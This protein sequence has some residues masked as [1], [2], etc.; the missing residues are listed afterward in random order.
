MRREQVLKICANHNLRADMDLTRMNDRA[1][2]WVALDFADEEVRLEKLC[3]RFKMSDEAANFKDAFDRAK[4]IVSAAET[5]PATA[6]ASV[7]SVSTP[8]LTQDPSKVAAKVVTPPVSSSVPVTSSCNKI[9]V[10]G[11][12]FASPP[13]FKT[14][15]KSAATQALSKDTTKDKEKGSG[16]AVKP[17][18]FA[19]FSFTSP[20]KVSTSMDSGIVTASEPTPLRRS[21]TSLPKP[22]NVS[23]TT[24]DTVQSTPKSSVGNTQ[25]SEVKSVDSS[26]TKLMF[27]S[28]HSD[29]TFS[30]LASVNKGSGFKKDDNFKG[31][32]GAGKSV[33]GGSL[34]S[35][36]VDENENENEGT[37]EEFVPTAEF[38]PVVPLPELVEL[39]T[40][41]EGE[42]ILFEERAKLLRFDSE[43]KQWKERG[44]GKVKI[45]QDPSTGKVR[46]LMRREQVLKVCCNHFVTANMKFTA[47][48]TSDRAWTWYAQDYSEGEMKL[49][50]LAIKFKTVGQALSFKKTLEDVQGKMSEKDRDTNKPAV[51]QA[52]SSQAVV[53][54]CKECLFPNASDA[55][56]CLSCKMA[57]PRQMETPAFASHGSSQQPKLLELSKSTESWD[58]QSCCLRNDNDSETCIGC[59]KPKCTKAASLSSA[60]GAKPLTELFKAKPG[61]WECKSCYKKNQGTADLCM[62][63][64]APKPGSNIT[65]KPASSFSF[66][67]LPASDE[68]IV[69]IS[70][71]FKPKAGSWECKECYTRNDA[72]KT[73]CLCCSGSKPGHEVTQKEKSGTATN[74][75]SF[76]FGVPSSGTSSQITSGQ[77]DFTFGSIA[78]SSTS[79]P[80]KYNFGISVS[81]A[82]TSTVTATTTTTTTTAAIQSLFTNSNGNTPKSGFS[83]GLPSTTS[84][85]GA[86]STS[87]KP[88]SFEPKAATGAFLFG[89]SAGGGTEG[90]TSSLT[91][92]FGSS[93][94]TEG[95]E[96]STP[97]KDTS[98]KI[99]VD[100]NNL[101]L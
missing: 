4:G 90:N 23:S 11:F 92:S 27:D 88:F 89:S 17:S 7:P 93:M 24:S 98:G 41:E 96:D 49:E 29:L 53:W 70:E 44:I 71:L 38:K 64:E 99:S 100:L 58:C 62:A 37:A 45:M 25:T 94:Q 36:G 66:G 40:G 72:N 82:S 3:V 32:E 12:T 83:F 5:S 91:F 95:K 28:P 20:P 14:D 60:S 63:C 18:P 21:R 79:E 84:I 19:G 34:K 97:S 47:L 9:T 101:D 65:A 22:V 42:N 26:G 6:T 56:H 39:K 78:P 43:G 8:S 31:W 50:L 87:T 68:N 61:L 15:S 35:E 86:D 77:S 73:A 75:P 52:N 85:F 59:K 69:P 76:M 81:S 16:D 2:M 74:Q 33:F 13:T 46:L 30:A 57:R 54:K 48:S 51:Q 80:V 1:W 10:G 67:V 55:S